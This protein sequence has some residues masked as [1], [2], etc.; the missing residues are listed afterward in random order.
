M[1]IS[2]Y[3]GEE[4][5]DVLAEL[6]EPAAAIMSDK[7][8]AEFARKK[9]R[10]MLIKTL[11]KNHKAEVIEVMAVLDREDPR[12]YAEKVNL[13]T[14]PKKLLEVFNDPDVMSL[15]T[16]QGQSVEET[17]S[18]SAMESTEESAR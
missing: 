8:I 15:F 7:D 12:Q 13:F 14:L 2:D 11:I 9:N 6:I 1:K 5:L 17:S 10:V 16:S 4:A 18:T 3:K